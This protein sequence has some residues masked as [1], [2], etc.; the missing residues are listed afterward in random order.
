MKYLIKLC[1]SAVIV[2]IVLA[3]LFYKDIKKEV[4][5]LDNIKEKVYAFQAGVFNL[6]QNAITFA[7]TFWDKNK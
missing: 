1:I 7:K 6:E 4:N 3:F 5:A 2:G